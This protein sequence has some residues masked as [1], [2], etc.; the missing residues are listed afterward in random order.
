MAP[1]RE[2]AGIGPI[3]RPWGADLARVRRVPGRRGADPQEDLAVEAPLV[4]EAVLAVAAWVAAVLPGEAAQR[5]SFDG[6]RER[7]SAP[8][9]NLE[10]TS[11]NA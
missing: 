7:D 10:K 11:R 2:A 6:I 4:A 9:P 5:E 3:G 8:F 1:A